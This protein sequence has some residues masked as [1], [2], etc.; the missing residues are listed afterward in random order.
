M[1]EAPLSRLVFY[2]PTA[3]LTGKELSAHTIASLVIAQGVS[4]SALLM[5]DASMRR[6][7]LMFFLRKRAIDY[8]TSNGW[9]QAG[10]SSSELRLTDAG[11]RKVQDR[12][13]GKAGAQ[14]V[15]SH[16]VAQALSLI[17]GENRNE[18]LVEFILE[19]PPE[20]EE[21]LPEHLHPEEVEHAE[22]FSEGATLAVWVNAYERSAAARKAC[23]AHYGPRC[24]VCNFDFEQKYGAHG[25]GF[26][27]VHHLRPLAEIRESYVV[28]PVADLRPVCPN[29]HAM[30]HVRGEVI[31]IA[32]LKEML[33]G[34]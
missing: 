33:R 7:L 14:S 4:H 9:L 19:L 18:P 17:R 15:T 20:S 3:E 24:V 1:K 31:S 25:A 12:L 23:I 29:C 13:N 8:W 21:L 22:S 34:G 30:L 27:H 11:L 10:S 28:D 16:Q 5:A 2:R 26:I 6:D 32:A